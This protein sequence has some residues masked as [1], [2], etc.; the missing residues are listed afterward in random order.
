MFFDRTV[1]VIV[2]SVSQGC[3]DEQQ[4]IRYFL[5]KSTAFKNVKTFVFDHLRPSYQGH[6]SVDIHSA[7][8]ETYTSV[9]S[10]FT[11]Y[12]LGPQHR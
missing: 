2:V 9:E 1:V 5:K 10:N 6:S 8:S 7:R 11:Q 12:W 3:T 4:I